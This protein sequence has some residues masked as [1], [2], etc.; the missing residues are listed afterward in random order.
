MFDTAA[1][2]CD[3]VFVAYA[4]PARL[5]TKSI[6][7]HAVR[8]CSYII[9]SSVGANYFSNYMLLLLYLSGLQLATHM[10]S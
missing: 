8:T 4:Y 10:N 6:D 9:D 5:P 1:L 3:A 2:R 7:P